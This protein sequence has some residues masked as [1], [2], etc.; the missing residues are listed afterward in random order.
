MVVE[1]KIICFVACWQIHKIRLL[2]FYFVLTVFGM[3]SR[4]YFL[5]HFTGKTISV[6]QI[7]P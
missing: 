1:T 2:Q 5:P 7:F 4:H 3:L 6:T